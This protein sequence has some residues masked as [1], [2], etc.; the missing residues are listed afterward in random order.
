MMSSYLNSAGGRGK[1]LRRSRIRCGTGLRVTTRQLTCNSPLRPS[2]AAMTC[3]AAKPIVSPLFALAEPL[4]QR[5]TDPLH[6]LRID[7]T[8]SS[9]QHLTFNDGQT[10]NPNHARHLES[11]ARKVIIIFLDQIVEPFNSLMHLRG[12][13]TDQPILV[14][15]R[16]LAQQQRR[17]EFPLR[18]IR[19]W[20]PKQDG[21]TGLFHDEKRSLRSFV[22][23]F[24]PF[25]SSIPRI[26]SDKEC[27]D[28]SCSSRRA[29]C[30]SAFAS[31][32]STKSST[33]ACVRFGSC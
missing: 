5:P 32:Y 29:C 31:R 9:L 4:H 18:Q 19:S 10:A 2:S 6:P 28:H 22:V 13:H 30:C 17:T 33:S 1:I 24:G 21:L 20:K 15:S 23:Y 25:S 8:N 16:H 7:L 26:A 3:Y 14:R 11:R 12:N 27:R